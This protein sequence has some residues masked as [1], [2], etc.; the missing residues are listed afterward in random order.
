ME[1]SIQLGKWGKAGTGLAP[2]EVFLQPVTV[3]VTWNKP[4]T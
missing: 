3:L 2:I 4:Y 1:Q